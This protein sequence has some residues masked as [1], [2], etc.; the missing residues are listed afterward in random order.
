MLK[1]EFLGI[2]NKPFSKAFI[3]V[4]G[5][6]NPDTLQEPTLKEQVVVVTSGD[7]VP[8]S[9]KLVGPPLSN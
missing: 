5:S 9:I 1:P 3:S 2:Q 7:D 4:I 6:S 8:Q